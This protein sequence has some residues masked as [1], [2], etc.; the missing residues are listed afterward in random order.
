LILFNF[1]DAMKKLFYALMLTLALPLWS[2]AQP[3]MTEGEV[4]RVDKDANKITLR[5]G[6]I[7][8][9]DMPGMTMVFPVKDPAL[10]DT[11]NAGDKVKFLLEKVSGGYVITAIEAAK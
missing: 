10:L 4:R 3:T 1:F 7:K 6:P 8:H 2:H 11:V 5:H 9:L